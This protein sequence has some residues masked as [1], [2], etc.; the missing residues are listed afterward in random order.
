MKTLGPLKGQAQPIPPVGEKRLR[1]CQ[2][3]PA[4]TIKI[5]A[6]WPSAV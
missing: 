2:W 4:T 6:D 5:P 1:Q 3:E